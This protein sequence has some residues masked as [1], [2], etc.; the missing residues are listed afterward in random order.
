MIPESQNLR[1]TVPNG[2]SHIFTW[3][4][5]CL[6]MQTAWILNLGCWQMDVLTITLPCWNLYII[7]CRRLNIY[8]VY[9]CQDSVTNIQLVY[10]IKIHISYNHVYIYTSLYGIAFLSFVN[11]R[12]QRKAIDQQWYLPAECLCQQLHNGKVIKLV[13]CC[14]FFN[15]YIH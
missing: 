15:M 11:C 3:N 7:C 9:V 2:E 10:C 12:M 8:G 13:F 1:Y 6:F 14:Y 4:M 5:P